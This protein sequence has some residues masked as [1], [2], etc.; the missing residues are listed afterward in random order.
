M[1]GWVVIATALR[2]HSST[3]PQAV[4]DKCRKFIIYADTW[5]ACDC[6]GE[7]IPGPF[8]LTDFEKENK[9]DDVSL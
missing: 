6:F 8:L 7:R 1:G 4:L 5:Y 9:N 3:H 2:S